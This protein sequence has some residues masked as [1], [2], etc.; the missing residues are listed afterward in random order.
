VDDLALPSDIAVGLDE[1]RVPGGIEI[2]VVDIGFDD[3]IHNAGFVLKC[4]EHD[5][6][7]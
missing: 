7:E 5:V 3:E 4:L 6:G 1:G 2:T